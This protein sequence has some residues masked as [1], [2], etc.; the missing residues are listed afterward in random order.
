ML[1]GPAETPGKRILDW[2]GVGTRKAL[3][4]YGKGRSVDF[5]GAKVSRAL[6]GSARTAGNRCAWL[7]TSCF[8]GGCFKFGASRRLPERPRP[9]RI[10]HAPFPPSGSS[11]DLPASSVSGLRPG[12]LRPGRRCACGAGA[13]RVRGAGSWRGPQVWAGGGG[14]GSASHLD[15]ARVASSAAGW[16]ARPAGR[17]FSPLL[18]KSELS[19]DD[20]EAVAWLGMG[21]A[22]ASAPA[23]VAPVAGGTA[24]SGKEG[25]GSKERGRGAGLVSGSGTRALKSAPPAS[26]CGS[27]QEPP[28][29]QLFAG[30]S[31]VSSPPT[32]A[33]FRRGRGW[34]GGRGR[35]FR[36]PDLGL[37][38][39][40]SQF[41]S[42]PGC[43]GPAGRPTTRAPQR[44]SLRYGK[45]FHQIT[46]VL[47][48]ADS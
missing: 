42:T 5:L 27:W 18:R 32:R 4:T 1:R 47:R 28:E 39:K 16:A 20:T 6:Q 46:A 38:G 14:A 9:G 40:A 13:G 33:W 45:A 23:S 15:A 25:G 29:L 22:A 11:G 17:T 36:G 48:E 44:P 37:D 12:G 21:V 31:R 19:G 7:E 41:C 26:A 34:G 24:A 30:G 2:L 43:T 8:R 3:V 35:G 10:K